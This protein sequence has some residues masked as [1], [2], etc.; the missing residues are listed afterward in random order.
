MSIRRTLTTALAGGAAAAVLLA[1]PAIAQDCVVVHRSTQGA[2][3][4]ANSSEWATIDINAILT[5]CG[6]SSDETAGVDASLTAAGA[7]VLR[8][9]PP[10][11]LR[12]LFCRRNRAQ[13]AVTIAQDDGVV[14]AVP[15]VAHPAPGG[16][17]ALGPVGH[18]SDLTSRP[19]LR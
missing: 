6:V 8:S 19:I 11:S 14:L 12:L 2:L 15:V 5:G 16:D 13:V 4:A 1:T 10:P 17:V 3:G 18:G 9:A 7:C